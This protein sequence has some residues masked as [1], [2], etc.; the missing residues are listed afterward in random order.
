[1]LQMD[2]NPYF[3][4]LQANLFFVSEEGAGIVGVHAPWGVAGRGEWVGMT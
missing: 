1:M 2:T 4:R 3:P